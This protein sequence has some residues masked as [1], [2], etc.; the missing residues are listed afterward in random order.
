MHHAR[1]PFAS[2]IHGQQSGYRVRAMVLTGWRVTILELPGLSSVLLRPT[3]FE[4]F[5]TYT[6][7]PAPSAV[8]TAT[9]DQQHYEDNDQKSCGVHIVLLQRQTGSQQGAILV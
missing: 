5:G 6:L 4:F 9:A 3:E 8:P 7:E 1:L 2:V